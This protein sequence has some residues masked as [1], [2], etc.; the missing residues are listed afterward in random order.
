MNKCIYV[1]FIGLQSNLLTSSD[2][3]KST[4]LIYHSIVSVVVK[5]VDNVQNDSGDGPVQ[6]DDE[7]AAFNERHRSISEPKHT[8]MV[9]DS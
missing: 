3:D 6:D 7:S 2:G 8:Q 5:D 9:Y 4:Y 1:T